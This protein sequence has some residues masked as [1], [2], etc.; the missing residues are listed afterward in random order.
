MRR[1]IPLLLLLLACGG[2]SPLT[3]LSD[4]LTRYHTEIAAVCDEAVGSDRCERVAS[5][6]HAAREALG[7]AQAAHRA[8]ESGT[9]TLADAEDA[10]AVA[11]NA[12]VKLHTVIEAER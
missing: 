8:F 9:G 10:I 6:Y 12:A 4:E 3:G 7:R 2:T 11:A 1:T 5:A